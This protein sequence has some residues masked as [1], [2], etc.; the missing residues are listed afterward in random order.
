MKTMKNFQV[1]IKKTH[2]I[3]SILEM[4]KMKHGIEE[5]EEHCDQFDFLGLA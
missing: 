2:N 3:Y 5:I 1:T 4:K